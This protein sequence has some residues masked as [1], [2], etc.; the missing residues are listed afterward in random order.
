MQAAGKNPA[1]DALFRQ[2][3]QL[4]QQQQQAK[5]VQNQVQRFV[6]PPSQINRSQG[7]PTAATPEAAATALVS[8]FILGPVGGVALGLAQGLM[9][10]R[11][12]KN[13]LDL[14]AERDKA[15]DAAYEYQYSFFND[16]EKEFEN[17]PDALRQIDGMRNLYGQIRELEK[18]PDG[19]HQQQ[20]QEMGQELRA[21]QEAFLRK[22]EELAIAETLAQ[23]QKRRDLDAFQVGRY[24]NMIPRYEEEVQAFTK[25]MDNAVL[26]EELL[27]RN[28]PVDDRLAVFKVQQMADSL[29]QVREEDIEG[30]SQSGGLLDNLA[31]WAKKLQDGGTLDP[32]ERADLQDA[33][34]SMVGV[35]EKR[36]RRVDARFAEE[37]SDFDLPDKYMDNFRAS[38]LYKD[39]QFTPIMRVPTGSDVVTGTAEQFGI[40]A[41]ENRKIWERQQIEANQRRQ[42]ELRRLR[43][44]Y[45]TTVFD[46]VDAVRGTVESGYRAAQGVVESAGESVVRTVSAPETQ[47]SA[48]RRR[49]R[50]TN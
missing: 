46:T 40:N 37:G 10:K 22:R 23:E 5:N 42:A 19:L 25:V 24:D 34:A 21:T 45:Y 50:P 35:A 3:E 8:G 41:V 47:P 36:Q 32:N 18:S 17:N 38:E 33:L 15:S 49:R 4:R 14:I 11:A 20:A 48:S 27:Q 16:M 1:A 44:A 28:S 9:Q 2:Q 39:F 43:D 26:A 29:G 30:W 13:T 6:G 31:G 7:E 12:A